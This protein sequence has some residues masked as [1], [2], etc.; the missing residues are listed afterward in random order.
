MPN[1]VDI[2]VG[3][4]TSAAQAGL[5][6]LRNYGEKVQGELSGTFAKAIA[7]SGLIAG[8]EQVI[9]KAHEI[10]HEAERFGV[11]AQ[12][13]QLIANAAK[14]NGISLETVARAMNRLGIIGDGTE[15]SLAT[16]NITMDQWRKMDLQ[17]RFLAVADAIHTLGINTDTYGAAAQLLGSRF[18][19]ELLP[20]LVKGREEIER[21]GAST[22]LM[23]DQTIESLDRVHRAWERLQTNASGIYAPVIAGVANFVSGAFATMRLT[24]NPMADSAVGSFQAILAA[25]K[26]N[27]SEAGLILEQWSK[28]L[29]EDVAE[30]KAALVEIYGSG[31]SGGAHSPFGVEPDAA[32][33]AGGEGESEG[34]AGGRGGGGGI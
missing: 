12:Q 27:F 32:A 33:G 23:S 15:K 4:D 29:K 34:A 28:K 8:I 3:A 10:H 7:F 13:L 25:A 31:Q 22:K 21:I 5:A 9:E 26:G 24:A 1:D 14:E 16:L 30:Y 11:D 19:T 2:T 20:V 17:Q 18:G 6:E